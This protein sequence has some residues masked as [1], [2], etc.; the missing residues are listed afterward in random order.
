MHARTQRERECVYVCV[1]VC[2]R[3]ELSAC[4]R[5]CCDAAV[6]EPEF[7][8]QPRSHWTRP[9]ALRAKLSVHTY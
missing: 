9:G 1:C 8:T 3:V 2:V 6:F 5:P 7:W 4:L